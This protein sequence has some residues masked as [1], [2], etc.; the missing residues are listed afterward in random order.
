MSTPTDLPAY[1]EDLARRA[2]AAARLLASAPGGRKN[3]WLTA[4]ASALEQRADDILR[5]NV[6]TWRSPR[7]T[8]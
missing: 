1:C 2:R 3:R 8:A 7:S 4:S 6:G 5:A